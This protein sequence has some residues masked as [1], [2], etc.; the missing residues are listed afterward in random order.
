[1]NA[2]TARFAPTETDIEKE[3]VR[4]RNSEAQLGYHGNIEGNIVEGRVV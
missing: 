2:F 3:M 4:K 1:M